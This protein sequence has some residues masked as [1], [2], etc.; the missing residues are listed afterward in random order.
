MELGLAAVDS[1][2]C[3]LTPLQ[4][5]AGCF[6]VI[7]VVWH[8]TQS[9]QTSGPKKWPGKPLIPSKRVSL[10]LPLISLFGRTH[11]LLPCLVSTSRPGSCACLASNL[12]LLFLCIPHPLSHIQCPSL[13][14]FSH[15]IIRFSLTIFC[16]NK[17]FLV[18]TKDT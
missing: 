11:V 12:A 14:V 15:E 5:S 16:L 13:P 8:G 7:H 10:I 9:T 3:K 6:H 4:G 1:N 2:S 17:I 18:D